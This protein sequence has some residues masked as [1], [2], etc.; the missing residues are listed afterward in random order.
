MIVILYEADHK[1]RAVALASAE[2]RSTRKTLACPVETKPKEIVGLTTI[3]YF[4]H[5]TSLSVCKLNP[6]QMNENIRQ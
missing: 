2:T 6:A 1:V 4:G 5:G 3:I